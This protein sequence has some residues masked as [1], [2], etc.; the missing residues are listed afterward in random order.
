MLYLASSSIRRQELLCQLG[1]PFEI[2]TCPIDE[3]PVI[4]ESATAFV[5]RMA[6]EK[7]LA[8][9]ASLAEETHYVL[10]ADTIIEFQ[11]DI[12]G[13]PDSLKNARSILKKLVNQ[14]HRVLTAVTLTSHNKQNTLLNCNTV[15]FGEMTEAELEK[16]LASEEVLDKAG[17]Y[18]IQGLAGQFISQIEGS[19]S[20]IMGLPLY[21]TRQLL[22]KFKLI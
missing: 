19:Y 5:K 14:Q 10:A 9:Q 2:R 11:G 17:A 22:R 7:A 12:I 21:E 4:D 1:I 18:G 15:Y 3:T 13:K 8:C 16:Y 20:G 6:L